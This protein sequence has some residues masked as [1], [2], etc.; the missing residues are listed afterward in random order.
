MAKVTLTETF[1][2]AGK[3]YGPGE[4]DLPDDAHAALAGK[5]A[6]AEPPPKDQATKPAADK[7]GKE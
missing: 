3:F 6:F 1:L 4:V 7:G 5:G 2:Y